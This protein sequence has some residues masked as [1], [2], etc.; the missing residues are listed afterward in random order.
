MK[1]RVSWKIHHETGHCASSVDKCMAS[2]MPRSSKKV[3]VVITA[4]VVVGDMLDLRTYR[5]TF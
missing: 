3:L 4:F 1:S 5:K 2:S